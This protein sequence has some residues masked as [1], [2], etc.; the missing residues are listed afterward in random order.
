MTTTL[1]TLPYCPTNLHLG[2]SFRN[3]S[4]IYKA[5]INVRETL[6]LQFRKRT[7]RLTLSMAIGRL[8][9]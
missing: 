8:F 4:G 3:Y 1:A 9:S 2:I 5:Q 7:F 6:L